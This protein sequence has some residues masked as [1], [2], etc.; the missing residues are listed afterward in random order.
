MD[1]ILHNLTEL[2]PLPP[3]FRQNYGNRGREGE[4]ERERASALWEETD[5]L[6]KKPG[7]QF[8]CLYHVGTRLGKWKIL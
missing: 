7:G 4:R 8:R 5:I 2:T 3:L 6:T 1:G